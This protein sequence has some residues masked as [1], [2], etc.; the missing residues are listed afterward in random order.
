M[1]GIN[2]HTEKTENVVWEQR[3]IKN[4]I[5]FINKEMCKM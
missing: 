4:H 5:R 3:K 1:H 2:K